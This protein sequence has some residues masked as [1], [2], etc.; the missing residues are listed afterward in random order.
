[1]ISSKE[2]FLYILKIVILISI[3]LWFLFGKNEAYISEYQYQIDALNTKIDSL[4]N[5]NDDL[6]YK[7]DTLNTQIST[8]DNEI[9]NQDNL[10]KKL[11][12]KTNEKVRAVDNFNNDELYQFFAERYRQH[13][14]SIEKTSSKISN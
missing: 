5:I 10:I 13:F 11:K 1:M 12:I 3:L 4:H 7:I 14:D 9:N 8:L 2:R 6:T